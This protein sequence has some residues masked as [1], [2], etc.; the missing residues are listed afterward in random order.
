MYRLAHNDLSGRHMGAA[1]NIE[2]TVQ[3]GGSR[4]W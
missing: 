3:I 1:L 4:A 2:I